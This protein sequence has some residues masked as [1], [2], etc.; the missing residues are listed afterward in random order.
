MSRDRLPC[1][2]IPARNISANPITPAV[3]NRAYFA[4][5]DPAGPCPNSIL[6]GSLT[7]AGFVDMHSHAGGTPAGDGGRLRRNSGMS[8]SGMR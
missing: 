7:A 1:P 4:I 3:I 5:R 6:V 8:H 2:E